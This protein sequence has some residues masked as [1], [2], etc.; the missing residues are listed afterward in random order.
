MPALPRH[1]LL[2]LRSLLCSLLC[3]ALLL[4]LLLSPARA[5]SFGAG[6]ALQAPAPEMLASIYDM[7]AL[8]ADTFDE[9]DGSE[10]LIVAR[11]GQDLSRYGLRHSHLA[12]PR[13]RF[14]RRPHGE[15]PAQPT[16]VWLAAAR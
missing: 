14:P 16:G 11:S 3:L 12:F 4:T 2:P 1:R 7:A 15:L 8:A 9:L 10:V 6:C 5:Q 13:R